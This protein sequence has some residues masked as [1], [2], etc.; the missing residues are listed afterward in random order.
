[1]ASMEVSGSPSNFFLLIAV[2]IPSA[3]YALVRILWTLL[4][5]IEWL[6][7]PITTMQPKHTQD[8]LASA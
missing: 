8:A 3:D 7:P 5:A 1:M 6:F 4:N 2:T